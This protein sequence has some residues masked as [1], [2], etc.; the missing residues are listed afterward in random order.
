MAANILPAEL[1][2]PTKRLTKPNAHASTANVSARGNKINRP[3][4]QVAAMAFALR[5]ITAEG[6]SLLGSEGDALPG[7]ADRRDTRARLIG[8]R[9]I[10]CQA[11]RLATLPRIPVS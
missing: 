4:T 8:S 11:V 5:L 9:L 2:G 10:Q 6:T 3:A 7:P 1:L